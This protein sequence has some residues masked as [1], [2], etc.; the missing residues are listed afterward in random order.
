MQDFKFNLNHSKNNGILIPITAYTVLENEAQ[1]K[2]LKQKEKQKL[3]NNASLELVEADE[4][5]IWFLL[6]VFLIFYYFQAINIS[7]P[8]IYSNPRLKG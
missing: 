1:E 8:K 3:K 5:P 4:P 6:I 7:K 2:V